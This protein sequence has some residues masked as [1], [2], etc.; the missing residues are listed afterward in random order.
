[1]N[2]NT[3]N[4]Q[5]SDPAGIASKVS[6]SPESTIEAAR[7]ELGNK[8]WDL[9]TR[10]D[11]ARRMNESGLSPTDGEMISY[12]LPSDDA[13]LDTAENVT[14][15]NSQSESNGYRDATALQQA[16]KNGKSDDGRTAD[17]IMAEIAKHQDIPAY[18]ASFVETTGAAKMLD[19]P[20]EDQNDYK[21]ISDMVKT[22]GHVL[23]AAS[24]CYQSSPYPSQVEKP[25]SGKYDLASDIYNAITEKGKEGR[26]TALDAYM[27]VPDTKYGTDFLVDLA[28]RVETIEDWPD[29][30]EILSSSVE[31]RRLSPDKYLIPHTGDPLAAVMGAM[32]NNPDAALGYLAPSDGDGPFADGDV[33]LPSPTAQSR[34]DMLANRKWDD[35]SVKG[36]SSAFAGAS[37]SRMPPAPGSD[38]DDRAAWA[39]AHGI[40]ILADQNVS[41]GEAA[42]NTGIMLGNCG[43]EMLALSRDNETIDMA[44][45]E[46]YKT[47]S[48]ANQ[49]IDKGSL[50]SDMQTLMERISTDKNG[51]A[52][53]GQ[54]TVVYTNQRANAA[55]AEADTAERKQ[56]V[57]SAMFN[58]GNDVID[59]VDK[60]ATDKGAGDHKKA[61]AGANAAARAISLIPGGSIPGAL[62]TTAI[63]VADA[64]TITNNSSAATEDELATNALSVAAQNNALDGLDINAKSWHDPDTGAVTLDSEE[65]HADF[66]TWTSSLQRN[67]VANDSFIDTVRLLATK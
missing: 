23:S 43:P 27:N 4:K 42:R 5:R 59:W 11:E 6:E 22:F 21:D 31:L 3:K 57:I 65:K 36:L 35:W 58:D 13:S 16:R 53:I 51:A 9:Q 28:G 37:A 46:V 41:N 29:A 1:M 18:G 49:G 30:D 62:A 50:K 52:A 24:L 60:T 66:D 15:Y 26:V 40:S 10:L 19:M 32:G 14:A 44:E 7:H 34:M 47:T 12:Y 56:A 25:G 17:E 48:L 55:A 63:S 64:Q 45:E 2:T 39:T 67:E 33:Y 61:M 54:G 8:F 20:I 38:T